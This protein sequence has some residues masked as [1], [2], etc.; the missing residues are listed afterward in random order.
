M[1]KGRG[2]KL[3][4]SQAV[5][6]ER[7]QYKGAE[8]GGDEG[9]LY[10]LHKESKDFLGKHE[11][12]EGKAREHWHPFDRKSG[13]G[14]GKELP[15]G[16]HGKANWGDLR[17]EIVMMGGLS[18]EQVKNVSEINVPKTVETIKDEAEFEQYDPS[19]FEEALATQDKGEK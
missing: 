3:K 2:G 14:R 4:G 7:A 18:V 11:G 9:I 10:E 1:P 6:E 15:K 5:G 19:K 13:T 8:A 12:Y 17:D 16:G